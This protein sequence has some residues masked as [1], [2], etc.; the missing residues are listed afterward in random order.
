[1]QQYYK[2]KEVSYNAIFYSAFKALIVFELLMQSPKTLDQLCETLIKMPYIKSKIS[3]DTLRVYINSFKIAGCKVEKKLTGEKH[4][5]YAYFIEE[6]PFRPNVTEFQSK[7]LF[8][9]YDTIMYNLPFE[10]L[11]KIDLLFR[12]FKQSFKNAFFDEQYSKH[13]LLK[14]F[15]IDMLATLEQCCKENALVTVL[16]KSPRSG[17]KE[18]PI[19]AHN[20]KIQSEKL[21]I[22]GFGMEY[23]QEAI[24]L[25]SRI[26][27]ITNIVPGENISLPQENIL[28]VICEF[29]DPEIELT[30]NETLILQNGSTRT[31]LH[32][33][34]NKVLS[35][36]RF[37]QLA[38]YCKILEPEEYRNEFITA[39]K[40]VKG[41]YENGK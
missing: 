2:T 26:I 29:Y 22:E 40:T 11:L 4:R 20:M 6:N 12:K 13:S 41:L 30:P 39:L 14:D 9:I 36:H 15:D 3:K 16:Y 31:I 25:I 24:F 23:K 37:L 34:D 7:K 38:N 21:Y 28:E 35:N 1:M 32:K 8:D 17:L 27:K 33:T 19:I 5:E 18:I 10:E